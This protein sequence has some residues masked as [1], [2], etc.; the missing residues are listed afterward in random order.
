MS[1]CNCGYLDGE[2]SVQW[3]RIVCIFPEVTWRSCKPVRE[4]LEICLGLC[5]THS[6]L[7][8]TRGC[9]AATSP[10]RYPQLHSG[11]NAP[12]CPQPS[13]SGSM[14]A[15]LFSSTPHCQ[16]LRALIGAPPAVLPIR[17]SR[18]PAA[19]SEVVSTRPHEFHTTM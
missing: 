5:C 12:L 19:S 9:C 2:I 18:A 17:C 10:P 15:I 14:G 13:R 6:A 3:W 4:L 16:I 7:Q 11:I 1:V 8:T